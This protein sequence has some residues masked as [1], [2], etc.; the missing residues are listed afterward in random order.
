MLIKFGGYSINELLL[1]FKVKPKLN[2]VGG[3]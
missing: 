1:E 3:T 2:R